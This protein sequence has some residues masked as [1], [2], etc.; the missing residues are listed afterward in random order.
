MQK[1]FSLKSPFY[2]CMGSLFLYITKP[3]HKIKDR[4]V[5]GFMKGLHMKMF[6][7]LRLQLVTSVVL[8]FVVTM[9]VA[10]AKVPIEI[11]RAYE[12]WGIES[13]DA[14][15]ELF[16][17]AR[18][19]LRSLVSIERQGGK[20]RELIA[21]QH[22]S[23]ETLANVFW[24]GLPE[25]WK[26]MHCDCVEFAQ[27]KVLAKAISFYNEIKKNNTYENTYFKFVEYLVAIIS[28]PAVI[29]GQVAVALKKQQDKVQERLQQ[30]EQQ[31]RCAEERMMEE[32]IQR[33]KDAEE[34]R[35]IC[36]EFDVVDDIENDA[37][38]EAEL[39]DD[40]VGQARTSG[41]LL[42]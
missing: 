27:D 32:D 1:V 38:D 17:K 28:V 15:S 18:R 13:P 33:Q 11:I 40:G 3:D 7:A 20:Q 22:V 41:C 29:E 8:L 12:S 36:T 34:K 5:V 2:I 16:D 4:W 24:Y 31:R 25:M 10:N 26:N 9:N 35:L 42:M 37:D 30:E 23:P 39:R 21:L 14:Q 19:M 6:D